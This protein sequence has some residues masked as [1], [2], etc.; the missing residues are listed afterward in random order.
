MKILVVEDEMSLQSII[1]TK[2]LNCGF[3][4]EATNSVDGALKIVNQAAIDA[5]WL[6]HYLV[7]EKNGL[8]LVID[9]KNDEKYKSIPI[10]VVSNTASPDKLNSYIKFG[11]DKYY[12]KSNATLSEIVDDITKRIKQ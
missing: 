7:G 11:V 9:L 10:F 5:I 3:D 8:D 1:K 4:V 6:D 2:L 12:T